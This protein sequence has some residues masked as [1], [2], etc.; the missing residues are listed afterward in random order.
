MQSSQK[1]YLYAFTAFTI[2][3]AQ[4]GISRH[5]GT[6]YPPLLI[7]MLRYWAFA[8]FVIILAARSVDGIGGAIRA[9]RPIL[10][11]AR[12]AILAVQVVFSILSFSLVGLAQTHA[13]ISATPLLVAAISVPILGEKVGWRRWLAIVV[14][15]IGVLIILMPSEQ[16]FNSSII[17]T[18]IA[19]ILYAFYAVLTRLGSRSDS[20]GTSFFYTGIAGAVTLSFIG[21]FYWVPLAPMDWIWMLALCLTGMSGHYLLI[22]ALEVTDA[23]SIQPLTYYQLVVVSIM[24]VTLYGEVLRGNMII[25]CAIVVAAGLFTAWREIQLSRKRKLQQS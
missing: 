2:F 13:L 10:Q 11:F 20:A 16:G 22:R 25:G 6:H 9:K 15:F 8:I 18:M 17:V 21:P 14:G 24:G 23:A 3:A 19:A 7:A 5:L 12:G 4:D 1:G